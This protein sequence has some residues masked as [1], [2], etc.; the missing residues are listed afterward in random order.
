MSP[1]HLHPAAAVCALIVVVAVGWWLVA[2]QAVGGSMAYL[3]VRGSSMEPTF[4]PGDLVVVR[5]DPPYVP[6]DVVAYR[7]P[8]S[9]SDADPP[10]VMHRVVGLDGGRLVL[11]GDANDVDDALRPVPSE[12][13]GRQ[14]AQVR[15][16]GGVLAEVRQSPVAVGVVVAGITAWAAMTSHRRRRRNAA[17]GDAGLSEQG[18]RTRGGPMPTRPGSGGT[19]ATAAPPVEDNP[20][21]ALAV[22]RPGPPWL[23][24]L[25]GVLV[26]VAAV[27]VARSPATV[28]EP[29]SEGWVV[30]T[31]FGWDTA[32]SGDPQAAAVYG[33]DGLR[34]GDT[35]FTSV[36]P[37]LPLQVSSTLSFPEV[38]GNGPASGPAMPGD[39]T[40]TVDA[41]VVSDAG[42]RRRIADFGVNPLEQGWAQTDV[43]IDLPA[44]WASA[45]TAGSTAGRLGEVR[46]EVTASTTAADGSV[47]AEAVQAFVL[48]EVAAE[49]VAPEAVVGSDTPGGRPGEGGVPVASGG[50]TSVRNPVPIPSAS[51]LGTSVDIGSDPSTGAVAVEGS[52]ETSQR[53]P[54][55]VGFGPLTTPRTPASVVVLAAA[56]IVLAGGALSLMATERAR[57]R[58]E[59]SL[60][61]TRHRWSLVP[62]RTTPPALGGDPIDVSSFDALR[63]VAATVGQPIGVCCSD[64][65]ATFWVTDGVRAWRYATPAG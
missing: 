34:T 47:V 36:T 42:W 57:R 19:S 52:I 51:S 4:G 48:D 62:L 6:G 15:G 25:L 22:F 21:E 49:P 46:L 28:D 24:G 26:V 55:A 5:D 10:V 43:V 45:N 2:P 3:V 61:A 64:G 32:P 18:G 40:L 20:V 50:A 54:G 8:G 1:M 59:A 11:R 53:V 23:W 17:V 63:R 35:V 44:A 14:V 33:E 13:L 65:G 31:S 37:L 38:Q 12:I 7:T 39:A 9:G 16:V 58:G 60:L 30:R 56:L 27:V 41:A 29:A